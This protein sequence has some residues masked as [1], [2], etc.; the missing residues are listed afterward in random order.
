MRR[1][2][3]RALV[4]LSAYLNCCCTVVNIF[5]GKRGGG[6]IVE[7]AHVSSISVLTAFAMSRSSLNCIFSVRSWNCRCMS[8]LAVHFLSPD[9]GPLI[10]S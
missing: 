2:A 1:D 4:A 9:M 10:L 7:A 6:H 5:S 8:L 3:K